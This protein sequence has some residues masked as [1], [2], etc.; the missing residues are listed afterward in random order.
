MPDHAIS[1]LKTPRF[2]PRKKAK[3]LTWTR[4]LSGSGPGRPSPLSRGPSSPPAHPF[5]ASRVAFPFRKHPQSHSWLEGPS[6]DAPWAGILASDLAFSA[7]PPGACRVMR[8]H[9]Q[10]PSAPTPP[11]PVPGAEMEPEPQGQHPAE[12]SPALDTCL[13]RIYCLPGLVPVSLECMT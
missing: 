1:L 8:K 13:S 2:W 9:A 7:R 6:P 10:Y 11:R 5:P 3:V 4:M 12:C